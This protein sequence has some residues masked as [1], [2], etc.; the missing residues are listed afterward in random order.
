MYPVDEALARD[1][2]VLAV[3]GPVHV[4]A[5]AGTNKLLA[6]G[7]GVVRDADDVLAT[8]GRPQRSRRR[9]RRAAPAPTGPVGAVLRAL[10]SGPGTLDSLTAATGLALGPLS[11]AIA[12]LEASGHVTR[13]GLWLERVEPAR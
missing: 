10:E 12:E 6:E 9:R 8:I 2:A 4:R 1:R 11:V 3:P 5:S 13:H 7:A